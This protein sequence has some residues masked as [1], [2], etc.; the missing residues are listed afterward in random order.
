MLNLEHKQLK[1]EAGG[2]IYRS[3]QVPDHHP[4]PNM[5]PLYP[6]RKL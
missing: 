3:I 4:S 5:R 1:L 2:A 6:A